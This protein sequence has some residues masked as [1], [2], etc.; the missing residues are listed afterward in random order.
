MVAKLEN[1]G[2]F[3]LIADASNLQFLQYHKQGNNKP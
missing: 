1:K 3:T 2:K